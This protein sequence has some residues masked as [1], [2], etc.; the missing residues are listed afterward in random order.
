MLLKAN[1][2]I[3]LYIIAV[4]SCRVMNNRQDL[5]CTDKTTSWK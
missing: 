2:F 3:E 4:S 1:E 5:L